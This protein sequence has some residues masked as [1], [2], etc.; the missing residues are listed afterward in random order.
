[1]KRITFLSVVVLFLL[2]QGCVRMMAKG[3]KL[4]NP[5]NNA[6]RVVKN[7]MVPMRD[8]VRL[9]TDIY[10]PEDGSDK[11]PVILTRMPYGKTTLGMMPLV[12]K[13][14]TGQ[15]YA[16]VVQD[17]RGRYDSEGKFYPMIN[18]ADDGEDTLKGLRGEP[19]FE[20]NLG[21]WGASY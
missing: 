6:H 21:A 16:Y 14:M 10:L 3:L 15:G 4:P 20:G 1:M 11:H 7:V 8:G 17:S 9:A 2:S 19:W 5:H 18:E 12:G 13:L